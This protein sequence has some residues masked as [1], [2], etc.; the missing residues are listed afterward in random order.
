MFK[1]YDPNTIYFHFCILHSSFPFM[2]KLSQQQ[3]FSEPE[4]LTLFCSSKFSVDFFFRKAIVKLLFGAWLLLL[5][6]VLAL[7]V[8]NGSLDF[9]S[10]VLRRMM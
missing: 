1:I 6:L 7:H 3:Y 2:V 9:W 5:A 4:G 10:E 8:M